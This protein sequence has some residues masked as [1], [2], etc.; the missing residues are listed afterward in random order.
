LKDETEKKG[1]LLQ[2]GQA[3][4]KAGVSVQ[5]VQNY[6]MLGLVK[7][8][9]KT[10]GGR[11]LFDQQAVERIMLIRKMNHSGYTLR[12]IREL[13]VERFGEQKDSK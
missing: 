3:A 8:A 10:A 4:R 7:P 6:I 1:E 2:I 12:A 9:G 5:S 11:R 13:F